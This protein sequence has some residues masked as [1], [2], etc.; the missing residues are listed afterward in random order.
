MDARLAST[1]MSAPSRQTATVTR[2][3]YT[4][5]PDRRY[6]VVRGR[7][8]RLSNPFLDEATHQGLVAELMAAKR[9]VRAGPDALARISARLK[10]DAVK[11]ALGERGDVWWT[12]GAPDYHRC[13]IANTPYAE[14]Y[15]A[16]LRT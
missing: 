16:P 13:L 10:V 2:P 8:W 7:V 3:D 1:Q 5:T 6:Y 12:D 14:W 15:S 11:R 9:T 4:P